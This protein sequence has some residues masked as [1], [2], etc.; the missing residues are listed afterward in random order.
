LEQTAASNWRER[1]MQTHDEDFSYPYALGDTEIT[2]GPEIVTLLPGG[3][4]DHHFMRLLAVLTSNP[5]RRC[6]GLLPLGTR[7][8]SARSTRTG[9]WR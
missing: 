2:A 9:R 7:H 8:H 3:P 4:L 5:D 1:Q 6:P